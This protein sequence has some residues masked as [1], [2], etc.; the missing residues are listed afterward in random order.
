MRGSENPPCKKLYVA[1]FPYHF[2]TEDLG[3]IFSKYG[4]ITDVN[5]VKSDND[6]RFGFVTFATL[7]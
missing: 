2:E 7:E 3:K 6:K 4:D 1:N 5:I